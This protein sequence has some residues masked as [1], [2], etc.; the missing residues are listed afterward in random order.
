MAHAVEPPEPLVVHFDG[1]CQPMNP[2]GIACYGFVVRQAGEVLRAEHGLVGEP[3]SEDASSN[4][5][6]YGALVRA[7]TWLLDH[8][9]AARPVAVY[10]DSQLVVEQV[11]GKYRV[12]SERLLPLWRE[13][14]ALADRFERL[15]LAWV[16]RAENAEADA[17]TEAAYAEAIEGN[18]EWMRRVTAF[19]ATPQELAALER[20]GLPTKPYMSRMDFLKAIK[21]DKEREKEIV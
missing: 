15:S 9:H 7:L 20:R 2:G 11:N 16:P 8:G 12:R 1:L 18:P 6:E 21:K 14:R 19:L 10:G 3:F 13:A 4:S 5:A 17:L